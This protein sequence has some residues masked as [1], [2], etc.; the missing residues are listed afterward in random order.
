MVVVFLDAADIGLS[1]PRDCL[2]YRVIVKFVE[3]IADHATKIVE[4][5]MRLKEKPSE[6]VF[7]KIRN[8]HL[9][10]KRI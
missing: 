10:Q 8:E 4:N 5:V 7:Q 9:R 1:Q 2:G 3:R 6:T